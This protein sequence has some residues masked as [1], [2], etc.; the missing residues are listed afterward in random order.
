MNDWASPFVISIPSQTLKP[1]SELQN[2]K[3]WLTF[4]SGR[5]RGG[6]G[7][8]RGG[9]RWASQQDPMMMMQLIHDSS[10]LP[11]PQLPALPPGTVLLSEQDSRS[12]LLLLLSGYFGRRQA[13]RKISTSLSATNLTI[14]MLVLVT[15]LQA[16]MCLVD[17]D[18]DLTVQFQQL[19]QRKGNSY[20]SQHIRLTTR[21]PVCFG[22]F[23]KQ[24]RELI[25]A[26]NYDVTQQQRLEL[27][28]V[29]LTIHN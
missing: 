11:P 4:G 23:Y 14:L 26:W 8:G 29:T 28:T 19:L 9:R 15:V 16:S 21:Q 25:S 7:G 10:M 12:V 22:K 13:C 27:P 17:D 1:Q 5:I 24:T 18:W 3:R 2:T 20:N 6:G